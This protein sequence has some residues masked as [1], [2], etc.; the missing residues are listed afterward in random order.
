MARGLCW[1]FATTVVGGVLTGISHL[2]TDADAQL[3]FW[4]NMAMKTDK[5][6][7][8]KTQSNPHDQ[9]DPEL[10]PDIM[11]GLMACAYLSCLIDTLSQF[12]FVPVGI[13][14]DRIGVKQTY[15]YSLGFLL[16]FHVVRGSAYSLPVF[17][18][19]HLFRTC[20]KPHFVLEVTLFRAA[21]DE[22]RGHVVTLH[23]LC[24]ALCYIFARM[25]GSEVAKAGDL[26][27]ISWVA[28]AVDVIAMMMACYVALPHREDRQA[29]AGMP[30]PAVLGNP[31][32]R[33]QMGLVQLDAPLPIPI[34]PLAWS[35][36][37]TG[38]L[39]LLTQPVVFLLMAASACCT[40]AGLLGVQAGER[41]H[42]NNLRSLAG[43]AN[44]PG[45]FDGV[46]GLLVILSIG[47]C[48]RRLTPSAFV[49]NLLKLPVVMY[50]LLALAFSSMNLLAG[51]LPPRLV[52]AT[53]NAI[54]HGQLANL[55]VQF[56]VFDTMLIS[57][58]PRE[59]L[60]A[61]LG[62]QRM[63]HTLIVFDFI[64]PQLVHALY[65]VGGAPVAYGAAFVLYLCT[66]LVMREFVL[67]EYREKM[68]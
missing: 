64:C 27:G 53:M 54:R 57:Y 31:S 37:R 17:F 33:L 58:V 23:Y 48:M 36:R 2:P 59:D 45:S 56:V 34:A 62:V 52:L 11:Q 6:Q 63:L 12:G 24:T 18:V 35:N 14:C 65:T 26:R 50:A 30:S 40:L 13:L 43:E 22:W 15:I 66:F 9:Q 32:S 10:S 46:V 44:G 49:L 3:L 51:V 21:S 67:P 60:G 5:T 38:L 4:L 55:M 47:P 41:V 1:F 61:V 7:M 28:A 8:N 20:G 42:S 25:I 16:L 39:R 68:G 29:T 19:S